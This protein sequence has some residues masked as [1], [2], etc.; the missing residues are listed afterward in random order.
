MRSYHKGKFINMFY[1]KSACNLQNV[2]PEKAFL[3]I[4]SFFL[5]VWQVVF[6]PFEAP[7]EPNHYLRAYMISEGNWI[8]QNDPEGHIGAYF[9]YEVLQ[10]IDWTERNRIFEHPEQK[11]KLS[12]IRMAATIHLTD[13]SNRVFRSTA[14]MSIYSPA[15]Y[16]PQSL[17]IFLGRLCHLPIL[18]GYQLAKIGNSILFL[19]L[20]YFAI[21]KIPILK[22]SLLTICL[23]PITLQEASSVA[24]D[25]TVIAVCLA[26]IA[27]IFFLSY[28]KSVLNITKQNIIIV[29]VL[30]SI[31]ALAKTAYLPLCLLYFLG[32][33]Q[34]QIEHRYNQETLSIA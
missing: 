28:D 24:A 6:P 20:S 25:S 2:K 34:V 1:F 29:G 19:C 27:Y 9:P 33:L 31:I 13:D 18:Y 8:A 5:L 10:T 23:L 17:G 11:Q 12:D 14:A 30:M 16:V 15:V 21:K 7:D 3:V 22:Y 32:K 4:S 26:F